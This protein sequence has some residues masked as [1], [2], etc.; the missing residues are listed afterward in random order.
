MMR[1]LSAVAIG[2]GT[3]G[4]AATFALAAL[5]GWVVAIVIVG[6]FWLAEP[7]HGLRWVATLSLLFFTAAAVV[8][9]LLKLSTFW[10][11][12][13]LVM[14]LAAWDLSHFFRYLDDVADVRNE[15]ELTRD[16]LKRLGIVAGLGWFLGAT[17]LAVRLTFDF[18]WALALGL[19]VVVSLSRAIRRM[20]GKM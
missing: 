7:R 20:G 16:H 12:S 13:S 1:R 18:G 2:L 9:V 14:L 4:M 8:G 17:A 6:L 19:V 11:L 5:W 10:L 3:L 15:A